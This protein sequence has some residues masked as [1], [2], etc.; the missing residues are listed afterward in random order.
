[1]G[2]L[3]TCLRLRDMSL[4]V[5]DT[6]IIDESRQISYMQTYDVPVQGSL[7]RAW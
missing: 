3:D 6:S 5:K 4:G 2:Y 1:M 7:E